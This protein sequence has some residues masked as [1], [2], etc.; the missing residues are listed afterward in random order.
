[1]TAPEAEP[2]SWLFVPGDDERKLA[3][4]PGA[5]ADALILDLEDAVVAERRPAA[6]ALVRAFLDGPA[7]GAQ[8]WVRVNPVDGPDVLDDLAAVVGPGLDG[9]V[10]PK[11]R[12]GADVLA[13]DHFLS[14]LEARA[15][16]TPGRVRLAVVATEVPEALFRLG[17]LA[18]CSPRL[19]VCTWGA[20]DL[21]TALGAS[22]NRAEDGR[23]DEPY[24]LARS[25]C[26]LAARA[27]G[28]QPVDT[29]HAAFED[30]EGL[31]EATRLAARQGFTGKLAI[32]PRQVP[33]INAGFTPTAEAV[34]EA[35]AVVAAF[36]ASPGVGTVSLDGRMLDRPHLV[37]AERLLERA[38]AHPPEEA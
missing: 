31:A 33:I 4:A 8:R 14:A 19:A 30:D 23:W 28:V 15:G 1:V 20:E 35:E 27:A 18:G 32:H 5:G 17:E 7:P 10:L 34:G 26:L 13:A 9:V 25:L 36:A 37:Q 29:L 6:R 2:R 38:A 24:A 11:V 12:G 16:V 3:T 22:T 21:G